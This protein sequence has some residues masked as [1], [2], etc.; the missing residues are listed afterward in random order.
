MP[1][2]NKQTTSKPRSAMKSQAFATY[3]VTYNMASSKIHTFTRLALKGPILATVAGNHYSFS[4][5]LSD[6]S[7]YTEW[8]AL[9]DSYR[10]DKVDVRI[11]PGYRTSMPGAFVDVTL[12]TVVDFDDSSALTS[13]ADYFEYSTARFCDPIIPNEF[14]IIPRF[15]V[16]SL[17]GGRITAP[18]GAWIDAANA[19]EPYYGLKIF[20]SGTTAS[21]LWTVQLN[22]H[23]SFRSTR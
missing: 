18:L 11:M 5:S 22:Y 3:P 14:S 8:T 16:Q 7:S 21:A 17:T 15:C 19:I 13:L 2:R 10:I 6:L 9:Y 23:L 1:Q 4:F 12:V 20:A